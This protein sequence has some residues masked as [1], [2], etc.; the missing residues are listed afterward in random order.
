MP[1]SNGSTVIWT[2]AVGAGDDASSSVVPGVVVDDA[3]AD[4]GIDSSSSS[5][6]A[7]WSGTGDVSSGGDPR[8]DGSDSAFWHC[9]VSSGGDPRKDDS[10]CGS[11]EED[12]GIEEELSILRVIMMRGICVLRFTFEKLM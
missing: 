1:S 11:V 4:G 12:P 7:P 6:V 5:S 3:G 8:K 10:G 9:C 2:G